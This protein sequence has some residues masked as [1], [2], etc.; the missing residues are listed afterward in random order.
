MSRLSPK[1]EWRKEVGNGAPVDG[2]GLS[3]VHGWAFG[4]TNTGGPITYY[5]DNFELRSTPACGDYPINEL[6][7]FGHIQKTAD[8]KRANTRYIKYMTEGGRS[9][10]AAADSAARVGWNMFYQGDCSTAVKRFDQA[11]LLDPKNQLALWGFA[12]IW[13]IDWAY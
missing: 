8:Q 7:M 1:L 6:P 9:R 11:W 2:L 3:E 5:L 4:T 12:V 10:E 13:S